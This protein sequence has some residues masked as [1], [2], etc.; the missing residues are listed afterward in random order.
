M[1]ISV[2][3]AFAEKNRTTFASQPSHLARLGLQLS[4]TPIVSTRLSGLIPCIAAGFN[5]TGAGR[6]PKPMGLYCLI[7]R[8]MVSSVWHVARPSD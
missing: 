5:R 3:P 7:F 8:L 4:N 6:S 2:S 1:G